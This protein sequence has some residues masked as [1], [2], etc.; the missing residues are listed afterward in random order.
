ALRKEPEKRYAGAA[1]LAADLR[2]YLANRPVEARVGN[3][4]YR[5]SKLLRRHRALVSSAALVLL[6]LGTGVGARVWQAWRAEQSRV[7][8]AVRLSDGGK[9][10]NR[11]LFG[12]YEAVARMPGARPAQERLGRWSM[13]YLDDLSRRESSDPTLKVEWAE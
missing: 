4:R 5:A 12:F 10:M 8:A 3:L 7:R 1:Q 9:L 11:L 2:R 6:V 13:S